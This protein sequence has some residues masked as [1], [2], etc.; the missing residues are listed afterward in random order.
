MH[1]TAAE[2]EQERGAEDETDG[3]F[4]KVSGFVSGVHLTM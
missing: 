3:M 2:S 1:G 4:H